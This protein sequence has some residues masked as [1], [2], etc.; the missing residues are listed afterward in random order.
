MK[1]KIITASLF[2]T[3]LIL[4][5]S[6]FAIPL[7]NLSIINDNT[8]GYRWDTD[9]TSQWSSPIGVGTNLSGPIVQA[10]S[11]SKSIDGLL[12]IAPGDSAY[13]F[14]ES[15]PSFPVLFENQSYTLTLNTDGKIY[16]LQFSFVGTYP[17]F[18]PPA[19]TSPFQLEFLGF[20]GR[21]GLANVGD[22]VAPLV[23][24]SDEGLQPNG[25]SDAVYKLTYTLPL[26]LLAAVSPVPE[27]ALLLLLGSGLLGL[28]GL[29]KKVNGK[30]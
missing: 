21:G 12:D 10:A 19:P 9:P 20:T 7:S 29:R 11:G 26:S 2:V 22:Q 30:Q 15:F 6:A 27:P 17:V 13:L 5:G 28:V 25:S 24:P 1:A 3:S 14:T 23:S 16:S 8:P 18:C 4:V